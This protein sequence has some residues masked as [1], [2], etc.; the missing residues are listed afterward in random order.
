MHQP[1]T[2]RQQHCSI[3]DTCRQLTHVGSPAT[4]L[5]SI[6]LTD[7]PSPTHTGTDTQARHANAR[8]TLNRRQRWYLRSS[9]RHSEEAALVLSLSSPWR[10][11]KAL[12]LVEASHSSRHSVEA[13][14]SSWNP[15]VT[16]RRAR[17]SREAP[18]SRSNL[19]DSSMLTQR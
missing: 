4:L 15:V 3:P 11:S 7:C 19:A 10:H 13:L 5:T 2:R 12:A 9:F 1:T 14:Q 16:S 17:N 6:R 18:V 8:L